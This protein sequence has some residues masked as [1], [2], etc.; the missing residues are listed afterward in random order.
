M[1]YEYNAPFVSDK[2]AEAAREPYQRQIKFLMS[3]LEIE[4]WEAQKLLREFKPEY[5]KMGIAEFRRCESNTPKN[6][7]FSYIMQKMGWR[8]EKNP[9]RE[10]QLGLA[11]EATVSRA[12]KGDR[13]KNV[14]KLKRMLGET[15]KDQS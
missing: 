3:E 11:K 4:K 13:K 12:S 6:L 9:S 8:A 15:F 1:E 7:L 10:R 5:L 2:V 14:V